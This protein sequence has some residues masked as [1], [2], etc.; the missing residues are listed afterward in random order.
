MGGIPGIKKNPPSLG[1]DQGW[2]GIL[3]GI[4]MGDLSDLGFDWIIDPISIDL[5][6]S[7]GSGYRDPHLGYPKGGCR[8]IDP[9]IG[10]DLD[11]P[12]MG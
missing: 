10:I 6:G 12:G 11:H 9:D 4:R 5:I 8:P 3:G 2:G 7:P 1:G